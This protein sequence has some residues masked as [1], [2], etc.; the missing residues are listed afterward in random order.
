[1]IGEGSEGQANVSPVRRALTKALLVLGT[2]LLVAVALGLAYVMGQRIAADEWPILVTA[3]GIGTY[4]AVALVSPRHAFFLWLATAPFAR[5]VYLNVELGRGIPNLTLTRIMTGVLAV[6]IL[7]QAA[8]GHR[9]LAR[10]T[11]ADLFLILFAF[12]GVISVPA[13]VN[14]LKGTITSFF[15]LVLVPIAVYFLARNLIATRR[16]LKSVMIVLMIVGSYLSFLATREQLTG[17]VWFYPENRSITYT[18][19]IRRVVGLLGNPAFIAIIIDMALPWTWYLFFN[20]KQ[21]RPLYLAAIG[22]MMA[23]VFFCMNRSAWAGML[24]AYVAM[25]MF[26]KRFRRVFLIMLVVAAIVGS[27]YWA[28]IVSS[29]A[30]QER[31]T[32]GAPVEYRL[33]TW[34][35]ALKI[36]KDHPLLGIGY[37]SFFHYYKRYANWNVYLRA[38]PTPHNTYLWIMLMGGVVALVPFLAFLLAVALS[39]LTL[40]FGSTKAGGDS[41]CAELTAAFLASMAAIWASAFVMDVLSGYYNT[42]ITF[43]IIG[44]FWGVMERERQHAVRSMPRRRRFSLARLLL[45]NERRED[46]LWL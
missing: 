30:V 24:I 1:M 3:T 40:Y 2:L 34:D 43:L 8:T 39:A 41:D 23:G 9:K 38:V 35:I 12:G 42:M 17:D 27:I 31:L 22:L 18:R 4:I 10:L 45:A 46:G 32:A 37:D 44:A 28:F 15:D 11:W 7:A 25:A 33:E 20:G 21:R 6:L 26:M 14:P 36:V 19:S 13:S 16:D 29:A 5:F